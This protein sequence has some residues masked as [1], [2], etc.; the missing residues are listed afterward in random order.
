MIQW[1][2]GLPQV[3]EIESH[4]GGIVQKWLEMSFL[5]LL[6]SNIRGSRQANKCSKNIDPYI[7]FKSTGLQ[8]N[9]FSLDQEFLWHYF[10]ADISKGR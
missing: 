7:Y 10:V 2:T 5:N 9:S 4:K 8:E 6:S 3:A 1:K